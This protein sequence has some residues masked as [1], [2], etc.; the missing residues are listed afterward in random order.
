MRES[1]RRG[2]WVGTCR[3]IGLCLGYNECRGRPR[4]T[5][6]GGEVLALE[7]VGEGA[8]WVRV[9]S[10]CCVHVPWSG[11][12]VP[13]PRACT[14]AVQSCV[15]SLISCSPNLYERQ[16]ELVVEVVFRQLLGGCLQL[17]AVL[18]LGGL[19][20][21][22]AGP[23]PVRQPGEPLLEQELCTWPGVPRMVET[24]RVEVCVSKKARC[25]HEGVVYGPG[26]W[27]RG[28]WIRGRTAWVV[29][30]TQIDML[31]AG[32]YT[33]PCRIAM[34]PPG[35]VTRCTTTRRN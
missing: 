24:W 20:R 21:R 11:N 33:A 32:S 23:W 16:Q 25:R 26:R 6:K 30:S 7:Q 35:S 13:S 15:S 3:W 12:N 9:A 5:A 34:H 1:G 17:L 10:G 4:G 18:D 2:S 8:A 31:P 29:E 22:R 28:W 27:I 19:H 14:C